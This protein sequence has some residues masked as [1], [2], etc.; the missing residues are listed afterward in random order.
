MAGNYYID[1]NRCRWKPET[2]F[3]TNAHGLDTA[4]EAGDTMYAL[5]LTPVEIHYEQ[6]RRQ[7]TARFIPGKTGYGDIALGPYQPGVLSLTGT[8]RDLSMLKH[9]LHPA[10]WTQNTDTPSAGYYT[11]TAREGLESTISSFQLLVYSVNTDSGETIY[12]LLIGCVISSVTL[13]CSQNGQVQVAITGSYAKSVVGVALS[14]LPSEKS[15]M[16]Y[17]WG[18]AAVTF[19][20]ATVAIPAFITDWVINWNNNITLQ[21]GD[22]QDYPSEA[23][24]GDQEIFVGLKFSPKTADW[25]ADTVETAAPGSD[26]DLDITLKIARDGTYDYIQ[27]AFEKMWPMTFPNPKYVYLNRLLQL[28]VNFIIKP[29]QYDSNAKCTITEVSNAAYP[30]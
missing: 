21:T 8:L 23:F 9:M 14:S 12:T 30:T 3:R 5:P 15:D 24:Y 13:S 10:S 20:L 7:R 26:D 18:K 4:N 11:R 28:D 1:G 17:D 2:A 6:S 22:G 19:T 27:F 16:G 25:W 29:T